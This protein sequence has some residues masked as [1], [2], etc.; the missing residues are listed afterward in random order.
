MSILRI[1][2]DNKLEKIKPMH[3]VNNGPCGEGGRSGNFDSFKKLKIPYVRNHDASLT[4]EYGSQHLVDVHC[5]FTDFSKSCDDA[6]AYDFCLTDKYI[7]NNVKANSDNFYRLGSSIEH[8]PKKYGTIV[9]S[10][11]LKWAKICEHIIMHYNEGWANGYH[12]NIIYW[13]IWNEPDSDPDDAINKLNWSG[14]RAQFFDFYNTV[15]AYLK[16]R[17]PHLKFGGPAL[18]Y[19]LDWADAFLKQL[20]APLDFFSWHLYSTKPDDYVKK[21]AVIRN[22]LDKYGYNDTESILNE[23]NHIAGWSGAEF[24]NSISVIK[25]LKGAAYTAAIMCACQNSGNVDM[26]MYYD[27]RIRKVYNGLFDSDTLDPLKTYYVFMAFSEIYESDTQ[28]ECQGDD[29]K[30]YSVCSAKEEKI[31]LLISAYEISEPNEINIKLGKDGKY[32]I[33]IIDNARELEKILSFSGN[34]ISLTIA[35]NEILFVKE[36]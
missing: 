34:E 35:P 12:L 28:V 32:E 29:D 11:F 7:L 15:A 23:Y 10:D 3:A 4:E 30:I 36:L 27:A 21:A 14:T 5:I 13:E 1:N 18:A 25:G 22:M 31:K 8:W 33:F 20:K 2:R 6:C 24:K 19:D 17:F 9:P 16:N 26:L